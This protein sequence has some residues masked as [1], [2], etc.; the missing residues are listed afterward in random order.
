MLFALADMLCGWDRKGSSMN[1]FRKRL[2]IITSF[3]LLFILVCQDNPIEKK[4][5]AAEDGQKKTQGPKIVEIRSL[6]ELIALFDRLNY[7]SNH[8]SEDNREVPRLTFDQVG[9]NW[10]TTANEIPVPI[11]KQLFFRLMTPLVL[12]ANENLL[13]D[14]QLATESRLDDP[15]LIDLALKY[16]VIPVAETLLDEKQR[17]ELLSRVDI[18]PPSLVLAQAAEESGWGCSRFTIEGNS[19]F[20]QWDFSGNGMVPA[21]QRK[22]LGNYGI[23]RFESPLA[24]V[25]GYMLNINTHQAYQNLR[26]LRASLRAN[27]KRLTGVALA[28]TLDKYSERG[29]TYIDAIRALIRFN[30]LEPVDEAYLSES[31]GLHLIAKGEE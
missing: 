24:S 17:Q 7:N 11:K 12:V 5:V 13:S 14:R 26:D 23:A 10:S 3:V 21:Q 30:R 16:K 9:E 8:W 22:E 20:G 27:N 19:F 2:V 28:G 18:L 4:S 29:Q 25:E 1:S 31:R 6:D 15:V